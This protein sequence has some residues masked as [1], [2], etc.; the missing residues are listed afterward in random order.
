MIV[1]KEGPSIDVVMTPTDSSMIH[2]Y[3]YDAAT[4]TLYVRFIRGMKLYSYANFPED[5]YQ[6]MRQAVSAGKFFNQRVVKVYT[7]VFVP[8]MPFSVCWL[9]Y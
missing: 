4:K 2:S 9:V 6:T 7:G 3:G 5:L 1:P 8:E